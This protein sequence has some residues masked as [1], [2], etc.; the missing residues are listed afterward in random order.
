[1]T[2]KERKGTD[3]YTYTVEDVFGTIKISSEAQLKGPDLDT[4][5]SGVLQANSSLGKIT[6]TITFIWQKAPLWVPEDD[7]PL[8]IP[9]ALQ[10]S[11]NAKPPQ[12]SRT[13]AFLL[14]LFLGGMGAHRFYAGKLG[15]GLLQLVL[16]ITIIGIVISG[17]W[18][19]I[20]L[21]VI[22][23]GNF[24]DNHGRKIMA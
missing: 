12:K 4:I 10:P 1:M 7:K 16:S 6:D 13:T 3:G 11:A 18:A 9:D 22:A 23:T 2:F 24:K 14:C 19:I 21:I 5:V 17:P 8:S 20:D 15:T